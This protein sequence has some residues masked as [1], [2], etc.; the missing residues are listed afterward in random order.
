[1]NKLP[2]K[3][4]NLIKAKNLGFKIPKFIFFDYD[5]LKNNLNE[6]LNLINKNFKKEKKIILRSAAFD[7]DVRVSNAGKYDSILVNNNDDDEILS[8]LKLIF[9]KYKKKKGYVIAQKYIGDSFLNG[10]IFAKNSKRLENY[11]TVNFYKG[12]STS[13][14]TSGN[15]NGNYFVF[16]SKIKTSKIKNKYLKKIIDTTFKIQKNFSLK[17]LDIEFSINKKK[18]INILQIR[19]LNSLKKNENISSK[20]L[21]DLKK[22]LKKMVNDKN[23]LDKSKKIYSNMTDWNPAEML[24]LK[25]KPLASSLY[26]ELITNQVWSKSRKLLGYSDCFDLPLMHEFMGQQYIDVGLSLYSFIPNDLNKNLKK[27]L[28]RYYLNNF[29]KKPYFY[30]DKIESEL[31]LSSIDFSTNEKLRRLKKFNFSDVEILQIKR[32][33]QNITNKSINYL[34]ENLDVSNQITGKTN[35]IIK[36]KLHPINKIYR[37]TNLCKIYGT[38][39]FANIAR[40]AFISVQFL[41]SMVNEKII[42]PKEH[43]QF[44]NSL[45]SITSKLNKDLIK[46]D[47]LKF[48]KIYGH[49]RP[50]TYEIN[51]KNYKDNYNSY[52][53]KK[54]RKYSFR[55]K[56]FDFD[57]KTKNKI[58]KYL[59][60]YKINH[61]VDNFVNF[62]EL[63][64]ISREKSKFNFTYCIN[65]IFNQLILIGKMFKINKSDLSYLNINIILDLYN[66]FIY[67]QVKDILR[68]EIKKNK[69]DYFFNQNIKFPNIIKNEND[70]FLFTE[71][72]IKATFVGR[73]NIFG[74]IALL[75]EKKLNLNLNNKIVLIKNADPGY[76]FI[77][78][79]KIRGL[80]TAYGGPNSH[81]FIRCNEIGIP[82]AIGI[83][84][85]NFEKLIKANS[86]FLNCEE[87]DLQII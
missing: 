80:I 57:L 49:L 52:F 84:D 4:S 40:F 78:S 72:N 83:G 3:I 75:N 69:K 36:E 25:P 41:N 20:V 39:P 48:L 32:S 47:K 28:L 79:K 10:V 8:K 63:S 55:T 16:F 15:I 44:L 22:K 82:A 61:K 81:M 67:T 5:F 64:I 66:K 29:R 31:I 7:E 51:S 19:E 77:F 35:K 21:F 59:K 12:K 30:Y 33:L 38:I 27:K 2:N 85:K 68:I 45:T 24:G 86:V 9:S 87:K 11:I 46:L 74:K 70:I 62:L 71:K 60:K 42:S 58:S 65:E 26:A 37:L 34:G 13:E 18:Q 76:D 73:K 6:T 1:M 43:F 23:L 14:I 53:A 50:N 17:N 54:V 56:K